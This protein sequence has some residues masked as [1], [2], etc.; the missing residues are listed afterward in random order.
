MKALFLPLSL[1]AGLLAGTASKKVFSLAW[2][3]IDG[4]EPPDPKRR[5][6]SH[7][8]LVAALVIEGAMS[9]L[10][11]GGIEHASRHGFARMTGAWPGEESD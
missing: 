7:R 2:S 11:R 9:R 5:V 10:V 4:H 6:E 3:R 1:L 8:K